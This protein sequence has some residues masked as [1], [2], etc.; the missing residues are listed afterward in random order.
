MREGQLRKLQRVF[1][2]KIPCTGRSLQEEGKGEEGNHEVYF[3]FYFK[4][5]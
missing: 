3:L 2:L 4:F 5:L 1:D